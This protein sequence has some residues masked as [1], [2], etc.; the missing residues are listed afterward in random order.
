MAPGGTGYVPPSVQQQQQPGAVGMGGGQYGGGVYQ[1]PQQQQQQ[2]AQP[3]QT[4]FQHNTAGYGMSGGILQLHSLTY[5][6][7]NIAHLTVYPYSVTICHTHVHKPLYI[8]VH[9]WIW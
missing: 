3:Q 7:R 1:Q 6:P 5:P 2:Q 4:T 9:R 8:H